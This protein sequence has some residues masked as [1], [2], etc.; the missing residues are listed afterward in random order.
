MYDLVVVGAGVSGLMAAGVAG[1]CGASVLLVDKMEKP[2][3]KLRITGKGRCNVTNTVE[4]ERFL[5]KVRAGSDFVRVAFGEFD[6]VSTMAFLESIGLPLTVERGERVFPTSGR[7]QDVANAIENWVKRQNVT[8]RCGSKVQEIIA[9]NGEV[10]GVRLS[11]G[12]VID[13]YKV[14]LATG[15]VS[16]PSTGSDGDGHEMADA[17]GHKIVELRPALVPLVMQEPMGLLPGLELRNVNVTLVVDGVAVDSRFGE[18]VFYDN[19]IAGPAVIALSRIAVDA[20]ID[21]K[22]VAL[23][24]DLKPALSQLKLVARIEREIGLLPDAPLRVLLDRIAPRQLHSEIL[25]QAKFSA[26]LMVAKLDKN[27]VEELAQTI[28]SLKFSIVNYRPFSEAIVT[29]GGVATSEID[30][31]T[32]ESKKIRGLY[33]AGELID[34]DADTGGYNIQLALSTGRLAGGSLRRHRD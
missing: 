5:A 12:E 32:M 30:E 4:R 15:G 21:N 14:I 9:I 29:A 27:A 33:F 18:V 20:I 23:D 28:K 6:N 34:I 31:K 19:S 10:V 2:A 16:Y 17:L 11:D 1:E 3:R 24:L 13:C 8:I 7:A 22:K 26:K 25:R